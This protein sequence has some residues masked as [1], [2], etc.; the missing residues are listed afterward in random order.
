VLTIPG[1]ALVIV[2]ASFWV[3]SSPYAVGIILGIDNWPGLS[4]TVRSQVLSIR[5][6]SYT[7][8][9][10]AMGLHKLTILRK[11][12]VTNLMPYILINLASSARRIIFESV[13][14]YYLGILPFTSEN[15]GVMLNQAYQN[16]DLYDPSQYHWILVPMI[17]IVLISL[18]FILFA[19][20]LDRV[21]NVRL[22]ARHEKTVEAGDEVEQ[23]T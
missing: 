9:S 6:E 10:R 16:M 2:L 14:L 15:W 20:G 4:R 3:P 1:L 12:V 23:L 18:G 19:Q 8:A 22:R 5:E 7:E 11:D 13:A 21:F 17:T